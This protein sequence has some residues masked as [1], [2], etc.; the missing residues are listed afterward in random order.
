MLRSITIEHYKGIKK[1]NV[2]RLAPFTLV[3][4]RNDVGKSSFLEAIFLFFDRQSAAALISHL[5]WRNTGPVDARP[6]TLWGPAFHNMDTEKPIVITTVDQNNVTRDVRYR[7]V[8][9][10]TF[11]QNFQPFSINAPEKPTLQTQPTEQTA[12]GV[13]AKQDDQVLQ[14]TY[15]SVGVG[16]ITQSGKIQRPEI[17]Q[18][19]YLS[20]SR[21]IDAGAASRLSRLI[22]ENNSR[23]IV[24]VARL[25]DPRIKNLNVG[26]VMTG[27]S[28]IMA[29]VEGLPKW[30]PLSFLGTGIGIVVNIA[31]A[32]SSVPNG[33]VLID[34]LEIGIHYSALPSVVSAISK[35]AYENKTQIIATTHSYEFIK[36]TFQVFRDNKSDIFTYLRL[37]RNTEGNVTA[38][39]YPSDALEFALESEWE[40]R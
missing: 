11:Q 9:N 25:I 4:G 22:S 18:A 6:E 14:D 20:S 40:I 23:Q 36:S 26:A 16:G 24:D 27:G 7:L 21:V 13:Y 38:K 17:R 34:E 37:E 28:F 1:L 39:V 12:I 31:L 33:T 29:D 5:G 35:I 15:A 32:V 8:K 30:V 10:H 19:I 3:G 2:E